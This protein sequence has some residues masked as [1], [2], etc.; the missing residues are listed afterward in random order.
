MKSL[1]DAL[2]E[3][4]ARVREILGYYKEI[5][6]VGAFGAAMIEQSLKAADKAIISGDA[7]A[8][9]SAYKDLQ[10]ITG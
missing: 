1:G 5:G 4:Q 10:E 6:P 8:M 9:A 7:A 2:P 3:E